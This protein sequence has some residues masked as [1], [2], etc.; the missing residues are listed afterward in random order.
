MSDRVKRA[1]TS[2]ASPVAI[3]PLMKH[4]RDE[5]QPIVQDERVM[6]W[7][8]QGDQGWPEAIRGDQGRPGATRGNQ[9]RP[10]ATRGDQGWPEATG[11]D[12][13][14]PGVSRGDQRQADATRGDQS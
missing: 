11:G 5:V 9:K 3:E 4:H 13:R 12:Q 6:A 8:G 2:T 7:M 10:E 1:A 14:R